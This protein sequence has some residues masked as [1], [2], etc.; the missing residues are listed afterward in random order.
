VAFTEAFTVPLCS[1]VP[2]GGRPDADTVA[3]ADSVRFDVRFERMALWRGLR[4]ELAVGTGHA[5]S[6][7]R[8]LEA[9]P[10]DQGDC[11]ED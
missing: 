11:H 10:T 1:D 9:F 8:G 7:A 2:G 4:G 6:L 5:I 3:S